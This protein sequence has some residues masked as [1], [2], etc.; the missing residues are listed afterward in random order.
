MSPVA[1]KA[2]TNSCL[3]SSLWF[4]VLLCIEDVVHVRWILDKRILILQS[5]EPVS[6]RV[7]KVLDLL[8]ELVGKNGALV[9]K[10]VLPIVL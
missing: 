5:S 1:L 8:N 4:Y 9:G 10:I 3:I 7:D 2:S 6:H